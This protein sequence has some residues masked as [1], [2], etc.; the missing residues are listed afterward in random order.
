MCEECIEA[1]LIVGEKIVIV[2][3][4]EASTGKPESGQQVR[5]RIRTDKREVNDDAKE[6]TRS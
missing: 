6:R 5:A 1:A 2:P 3:E 4:V